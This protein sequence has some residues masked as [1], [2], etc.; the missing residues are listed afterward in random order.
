MLSI[1]FKSPSCASDVSRWGIKITTFSGCS[2]I[3]S[4]FHSPLRVICWNSLLVLGRSSYSWIN[5]LWST[6]TDYLDFKEWRICSVQQVDAI[7]EMSGCRGKGTGLFS[8][9]AFWSLAESFRFSS[10]TESTRDHAP[11]S[12]NTAVSFL[13]K[14]VG[15]CL[16]DLLHSIKKL[17]WLG[18]AQPE[19]SPFWLTQSQLMD[20]LDHGNDVPS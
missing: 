4:L 9:Q 17:A 12:H 8:L 10:M 20:I 11:W 1:Q 6:N 14:L 5:W 18:W 19:Q 15:E 13:S 7:F 3:L 16:S 2:V